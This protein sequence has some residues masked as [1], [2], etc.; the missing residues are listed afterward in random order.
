MIF[1]NTIDGNMKRLLATVESF[2]IFDS[3]SDL[4]YT[5]K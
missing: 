5:K 1:Y 4:A 2:Y 3:F